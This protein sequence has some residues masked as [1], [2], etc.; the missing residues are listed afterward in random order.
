M[1]KVSGIGGIFF[2]AR[3][4]KALGAWYETHLGVKFEDWG[5]TQ[6]KWRRHDAP[7]RTEITVW[8]L[9]KQ[10]STYFEPGGKPFMVNYIVDDLDAMRTQLLAAGV[11]VDDKVEASEY[12]RFGW[13]M[14]PEGNRFELWE[15]PRETG[16]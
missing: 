3:D 8:S 12:G 6:F 13:A 7:E 4:P 16:Q 2:K 11:T 1:N 14:D 9:F 5:G 15:P 10:D